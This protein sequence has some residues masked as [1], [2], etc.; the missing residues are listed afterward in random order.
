MRYSSIGTWLRHCI[1]PLGPRT[2]GALRFTLSPRQARKLLRKAETHH[3]LSPVLR[4]LPLPAQDPAFD[5]IRQE[6]DSTRIAALALSA[7]LNQHATRILDGTKGLP[8]TIVKGP[9]F[10]RRI[11]P[12]AGLRPFTDLDLL[13]RPE[14]SAQLDSVLSDQEFIRVKTGLEPGRLE[15]KWIHRTTG[16]LVEV[17]TDL[18]HERRMRTAF[19][20]TYQDLEGQDQSPAA[21]LAVAVT[22][23]TTHFFAWLRHVVDI[24]Q[25]ARALP[26]EEEA[27][28]EALTLRTGTRFAA[29]VGLTLAYRV[30]GEP[31]CLDIAQA[32][33]PIRH[34]RIAQVL[35]QGA[36]LTATSNSWLLYNTWRRFLFSELLR[37]GGLPQHPGV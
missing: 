20:L 36:D 13:V 18:V 25:A 4:T 23:G 32:L 12:N 37:Y 30:V 26:P 14:A 21:M 9:T 1:D 28:F 6:A 17:H 10:A 15:T 34:A 11:Y 33:G 3:V 24:C 2:T 16:A 19:S 29:I 5:Q 7:M 31:R 35:S 8:V 22:H 27:R